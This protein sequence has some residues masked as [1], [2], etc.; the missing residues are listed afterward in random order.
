VQT[1]SLKQE[2]DFLKNYLEIQ[3]TRFHDRLTIN[4]S[5]NNST[6]TAEV[7][8]LLLQPLVENSIKHGISP[9]AE[10]GE[11]TI[12]SDIADQLLVLKVTDDGRGNGDSDIIEGIGIKNIRERLNQM[13]GD[14]YSMNFL[15]G[16]AN[17]FSVVIKLPFKELEKNE[18]N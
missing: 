3:Q 9:R 4:Y 2:L 16:N 8:N 14:K 11:I 18:Q 13:Y 1:V 6:L 7:P 5:I 10:G 15:S 17:G 12:Y